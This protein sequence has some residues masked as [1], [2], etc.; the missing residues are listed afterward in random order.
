MGKAIAGGNGDAALAMSVRI[1][2]TVDNSPTQQDPDGPCEECWV[3]PTGNSSGSEATI[4]MYFE[5][6]GENFAGDL[7]IDVS[8]TGG[9]SDT[10]YV[11]D[12]EID[13]A[14]SRTYYVAPGSSW[15]WNDVDSLVITV[16]E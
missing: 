16:V 5:D 9:G 3:S 12:T 6:D 2:G 15:N 13:H 4:E 11:Y 1:S 14:T 10:V 8:L 7:E